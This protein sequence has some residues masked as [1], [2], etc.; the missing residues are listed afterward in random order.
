MIR[1]LSRTILVLVIIGL[2]AIN[3]LVWRTALAPRVLTVTIFETGKGKA[4]LATTPSGRTLLIDNN[5]DASIL[6][7]LGSTLPP[8]RRS[9]DVVIPLKVGAG[10]SEVQNRYH[11]T[12]LMRSLTRGQRINFHDGTFIDVLWPPNKVGEAPVF[13]LS[14][15]TTSF[16]IK[17]LISARTEKY[18][19][20]ISSSL[21]S[22][23]FVISSSTPAGVFISNGV[24]VSTNK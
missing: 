19:A 13:L 14:Y 2:T 16:L 6:R 15:G 24:T 1:S 7:S 12:R 11:I 20:S 4:V 23:S 5:S 3:A 17:P 10:L 22:P 9:L 21:P 18:L 8:W